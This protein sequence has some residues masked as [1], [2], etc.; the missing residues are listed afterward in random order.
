LSAQRLGC[1]ID[2][3]HH[4]QNRDNARRL[5]ALFVL[6]GISVIAVAGF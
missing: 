6:L 5:W 2:S 3:A 1:Y 4:A